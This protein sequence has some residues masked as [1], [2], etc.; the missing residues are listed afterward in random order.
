MAVAGE[1]S[2]AQRVEFAERLAD[3]GLVG[4]PKRAQEIEVT[5]ELLARFGLSAGQTLPLDRVVKLAALLVQFWGIWTARPSI[6]CG[7]YIPVPP[8]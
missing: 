5:P 8:S 7:N 6:F 3:A 1:L 4:A 2:A